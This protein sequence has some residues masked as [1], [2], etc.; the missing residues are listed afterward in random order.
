MYELE[1]TADVLVMTG[2]ASIDSRHLGVAPAATAAAP[3]LE[4]RESI[5]SQ[6]SRESVQIGRAHV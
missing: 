2:K 6:E 1:A 5:V 4:S 3:A